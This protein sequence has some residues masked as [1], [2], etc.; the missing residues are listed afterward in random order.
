MPSSCS[1]NPSLAIKR[2]SGETNRHVHWSKFPHMAAISNQPSWKLTLDLVTTSNR[3]RGSLV[4][5]RIYS[6]RDLQL[7]VNLLTSDFPGSLA[8]ALDRVL[9][10]PEVLVAGCG[11]PD[12]VS[13]RQSL[14]ARFSP[15]CS[16]LVTPTV[17]SRRP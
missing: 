7:D 9:T 3:R 12:F 8:D 16:T 11:R 5:Y 2:A 15:I 14:A 4:V 10:S 1:S 6:P 17:R 13:R